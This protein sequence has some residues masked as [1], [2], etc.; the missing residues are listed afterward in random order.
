MLS[1]YQTKRDKFYLIWI[2][3]RYLEPIFSIRLINFENRKSLDL[4]IV[5]YRSKTYWT[6]I[7]SFV[8]ILSLVKRKHMWRLLYKRSCLHSCK[9]HTQYSDTVCQSTKQPLE[10]IK[11]LN[12]FSFHL[13]LG[14]RNQFGQCTRSNEYTIWIVRMLFG[15]AQ[16]NHRNL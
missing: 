1:K 8:D 6:F 11:R 4:T 9:K 15:I 13:H 10:I 16:Q 5:K 3:L 2:F 12:Q 14:W 7:T